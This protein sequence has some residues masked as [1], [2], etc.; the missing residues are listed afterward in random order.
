MHVVQ[1]KSES[2]RWLSPDLQVGID[3]SYP[4]VPTPVDRPTYYGGCCDKNYF[5]R[6]DLILEFYIPQSGLL[7]LAVRC[8]FISV[9]YHSLFLGDRL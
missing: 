9:L 1:P 2:E 5:P 7:P 4:Q 3:P 8:D 6:C